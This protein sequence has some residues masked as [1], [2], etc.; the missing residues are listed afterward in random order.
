MTSQPR[1]SEI[2][3]MPLGPVCEMCEK[4]P[5]NPIYHPEEGDAFC[6]ECV[7]SMLVA[8]RDHYRKALAALQ[9]EW[10]AEHGISASSD[11]ICER[12]AKALAW[13]E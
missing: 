6:P 1:Q 4:R 9:D 5:A 11:F 2:A 8:E 12:V 10:V 7:I 13:P 3:P